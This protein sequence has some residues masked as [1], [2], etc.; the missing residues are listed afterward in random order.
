MTARACCHVAILPWNFMCV[1]VLCTLSNLSSCLSV[2][3]SSRLRVS[4]W[5][6]LGGLTRNIFV[7]ASMKIRIEI[8]NFGKIGPRYWVL[9]LKTEVWFIVAGVIKLSMVSGW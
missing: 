6:P 7:G 9:Y 4:A 1:L 8:P 5:L 3:L 2:G